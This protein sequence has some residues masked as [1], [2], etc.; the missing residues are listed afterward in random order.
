M[1]TP[2]LKNTDIKDIIKGTDNDLA[3][4]LLKVIDAKT[5]IDPHLRGYWYEAGT[6]LSK[7]IHRLDEDETANG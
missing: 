1:I 4:C 5:I 3:L 2:T 6:L 7:I